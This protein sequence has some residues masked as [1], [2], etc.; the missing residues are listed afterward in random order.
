MSRCS[1]LQH[2]AVNTIFQYKKIERWQDN[3]SGKKAY[4]LLSLVAKSLLAWQFFSG[5]STELSYPV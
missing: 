5:P 1:V 4:I 2:F 3:I